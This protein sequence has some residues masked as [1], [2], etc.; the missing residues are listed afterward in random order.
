MKK[1]KKVVQDIDNESIV[2]KIIDL[3]LWYQIEDSHKMLN[4]IDLQ[5]KSCRLQMEYLIDTK[6][7]WFQKKKLEEYNKKMEELDNQIF[8][9]YQ[10]MNEE[11]ELIQKMQEKISP[12][13]N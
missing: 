9:Y 6:P 1:E 12:Q 2:N 11:V 8:K 13:K 7:F 5:I 3:C 4:L 10:D